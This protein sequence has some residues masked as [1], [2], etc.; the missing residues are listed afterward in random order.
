MCATLPPTSVVDQGGPA[1]Y[2]IFIERMPTTV[3]LTIYALIFTVTVGMTLG[4]SAYKRNSA[5]DV[6]TMFVANIVCRF[7]IR[8]R[9]VAGLVLRDLAAATFCAASIGPPRQDLAARLDRRNRVWPRAGPPRR[10]GLSQRAH[11]PGSD[12]QWTAVLRC[13][14]APPARD[15][16]NTI[17]GDLAPRRLLDVL[18]TFRPHGQREGDVAT[19]RHVPARPPECAAAIVTVIG[20]SVGALLG[21]VLTE[22][23][24]L[25]AWARPSSSP[26]WPP[27]NVVRKMALVV[28]IIYVV[29]NLVVDVSYGYLDPRVRVS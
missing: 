1:G 23:F 8:A 12:A 16:Q 22:I 4:I 15:A 26:Q 7:S 9:P 29:V 14:P 20:L 5:G 21:A 24:N 11:L 2:E 10:S 18:G 25:L 27:Y 3:E 13:F 6:G 28:A 17:D 19:H